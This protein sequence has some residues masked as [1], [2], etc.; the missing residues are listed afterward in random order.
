MGRRHAARAAFEIIPTLQGAQ[1]RHDHAS[2]FAVKRHAGENT[3]P[4]PP[5]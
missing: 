2:L 1:P 5:F 4:L 3:A